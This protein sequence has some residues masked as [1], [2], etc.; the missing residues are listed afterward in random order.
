[1]SCHDNNNN[2]N[3]NHLFLVVMPPLYNLGKHTKWFDMAYNQDKG[4]RDEIDYW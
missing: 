2:N 3:N 4:F 1:L